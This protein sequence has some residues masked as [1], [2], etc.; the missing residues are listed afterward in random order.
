MKNKLTPD[1]IR[2]RKKIHL[3]NLKRKY[4]RLMQH[5]DCTEECIDLK[6]D[7]DCLE[8]ELQ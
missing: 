2:Y 7:I 5:G 4:A 8:K 3:K 6:A 1:D